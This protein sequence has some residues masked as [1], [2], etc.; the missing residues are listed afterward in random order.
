MR[1]SGCEDAGA[2]RG[3]PSSSICISVSSVG[4][5]K[6]EEVAAC[7]AVI[8]ST[9]RLSSAVLGGRGIFWASSLARVS[10]ARCSAVGAGMVSSA[11]GS[12]E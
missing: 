5:G 8:M 1:D 3:R 11:V 4:S 2:N 12:K 7:V 6:G 10:G 9:S